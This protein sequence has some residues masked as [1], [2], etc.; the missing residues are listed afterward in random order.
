VGIPLHFKRESSPATAWGGA[1]SSTATGS[2]TPRVTWTDV[3]SRG[4]QSYQKPQNRSPKTT[5]N[6]P[7]KKRKHEK[8][9]DEE[10]ISAKL[11]ELL[12]KNNT[13]Q[14]EWLKTFLIIPTDELTIWITTAVKNLKNLL[15]IMQQANQNCTSKVTEN[16]QIT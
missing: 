9:D 5:P 15:E 14:E 2:A 13:S 11:Y 8:S 6:A 4:K 10:Q 3:T 1:S 7:A 16:E 12:T